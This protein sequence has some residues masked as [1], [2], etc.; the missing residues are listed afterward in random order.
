MPEANVVPINRGPRFDRRRVAERAMHASISTRVRAGLDLIAPVC[1]FDLCAKLGVRVAFNDIDMEG[2]YQRGRTPRIHLSALRPLARRTFNCAHELGHHELGHGSTIDEL[3][4]QRSESAWDVPEEY[5]ADT[6]AGH[7]LMP[8]L[9]LE[10]AF[11]VRGLRPAVATAAQLYR[12]ACQFHVGLRT[13]ATHL[14]FGAGLVSR[15]RFDELR[16]ATP[17]AIRAE[18]LGDLSASHLVVADRHYTAR[19]VDLEVGDLALLPA[20]TM[21]S[22]TAM[23]F[24]R[25][26]P[27]GRL[28]R[29]ERPGIS[30]LLTPDGAWCAFGRVCRKEYVG[31]AEFRHLEDED[32]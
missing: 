13:L 6:F 17:K 24:A 9:G 25:D 11:V 7:L 1:V 27:T 19:T 16:R 32:D 29:A 2:M 4:R 23:E 21:A 15:Q 22:G 8:A 18:I 3:N 20:G 5:M 28:F 26:L 12:I 14:H 10:N 30:Q 31:R